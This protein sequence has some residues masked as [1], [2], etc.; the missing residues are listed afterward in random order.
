MKT[1]RRN[2]NMGKI[3]KGVFR[4]KGGLVSGWE[5]LGGATLQV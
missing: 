1:G 3:S 2:D 5:G 4:R